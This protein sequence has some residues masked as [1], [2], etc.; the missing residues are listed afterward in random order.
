MIQEDSLF[1]SGTLVMSDTPA[2]PA[3]S[4]PSWGELSSNRILTV[5][6]IVLFIFSLR[7]LFR[8]MPPLMYSAGRARGIATLEHNVSLARIRNRI[9]ALCILPF[10]LVADR[11]ALYRPGFFAFIPREWTAPATIVV[12]LALLLLRYICRMVFRPRSLNA[13]AAAS[14]SK[15]IYTFFIPFCFLMLFSA[16]VMTLFGI[17]D[18]IG[19][20]VLYSELLLLLLFSMTRTAQFLNGLCAKLP[21]F[22]YLCALE[23][24]PVAI[25]VLSSLL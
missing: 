17:P 1:R 19:R 18:H 16:G 9:A 25:L 2:T 24:M 23:L 15:C 5:L 21:V 8:L 20:I 13:E 10:C 3:E 4:V 6:A 11:Y 7:S 22:L 12:M 14:A